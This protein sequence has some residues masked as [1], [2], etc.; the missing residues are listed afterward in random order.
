LFLARFEEIVQR[1][2]IANR[3]RNPLAEK[4]KGE[5]LSSSRNLDLLKRLTPN[6]VSCA[7]P[8]RRQGW[9]RRSTT[10]CGYCIPC[11]CRR[12][13]LHRIGLDE[14]EAYGIDI[15]AGEMPLHEDVASDLRAVL[16]FIYSAQVGD[17][18]P[19]VV[20]N[21]MPLPPGVH[22]VAVRILTAGIDEL[23]QLFRD[24]AIPQVQAWGGMV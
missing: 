21:Q 22:P 24:K 15:C 8:T 23:V 11:I 7:H 19:E 12:A 1:L 3:I 9:I 10:H 5:T 4:T 18:V 20:A 6:T 17:F 14:G 13:A 2:G 16:S